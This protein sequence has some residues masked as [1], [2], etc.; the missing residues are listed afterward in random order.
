MIDQTIDLAYK[1]ALLN[2]LP[3]T[4]KYYG[5]IKRYAELG[6]GDALV[7]LARFQREADKQL[8]LNTLDNKDNQYFGFKAIREFPDKDFFKPL[9]REFYKRWYRTHYNYPELRMIYQALAKYP[10]QKGAIKIFNKTTKAWGR[11]KRDHFSTY[12]KVAITKY[13]HKNF[14]YLVDRIDLSDFN[15]SAFKDYL[16][17]DK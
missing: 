6:N 11:W 14:D 12:V 8:I 16:E 7:T 9:K 5:I 17:I 4:D 1:N 2:E 3:A 13:P 15:E 10:E